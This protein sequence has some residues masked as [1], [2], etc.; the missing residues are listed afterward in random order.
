MRSLENALELLAEQDQS[1]PVET[2]SDRIDLRLRGGAELHIADDATDTR[3]PR[4]R[5]WWKRGPA[6]AIA[7]ALA[8]VVAVG[9]PIL[10]T[11]SGRSTPGT[12][13]PVATTGLPTVSTSLPVVPPTVATTATTLPPA[14]TTQP[15]APFAAI[16]VDLSLEI[17][18]TTSVSAGSFVAS[19]R[20]VDQGSMCPGGTT[21][22]NSHDQTAS[23]EE[24]ETRFVCDDGSGSFSLRV[25]D[26]GEWS[27]TPG[28]SDWIH[29]GTWTWVT[30]KGTTDYVG[31]IGSGEESGRCP[32][33]DDPCHEEYAGQIQRDG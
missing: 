21:F 18:Q 2:L 12:T 28:A 19:G 9:L 13:L 16:D 6:V 26:V 5:P 31:I 32:M 8:V 22:E 29:S 20:A 7:A 25:V 14:T 10:L 27:G 11:N 30:E 23:G 24:W 3:R 33:G 17:D 15:L 4:S 1:L